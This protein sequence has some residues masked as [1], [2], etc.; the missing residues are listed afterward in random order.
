ML[1]AVNLRPDAQINLLVATTYISDMHVPAAPEQ[2]QPRL[3]PHQFVISD[4][5]AGPH[6]TRGTQAKFEGSHRG[7]NR[8]PAL[9]DSDL[10]EHESRHI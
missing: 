9:A 2:P 4:G 8:P 7:A 10:P 3:S 5:A 6:A 1:W